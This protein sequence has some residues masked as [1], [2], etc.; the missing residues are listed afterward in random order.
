MKLFW[1]VEKVI[2]V[3][4][5]SSD[6][7]VLEW[8]GMSVQY[9]YLKMMDYQSRE[10][11]WAWKLKHD[12]LKWMCVSN[13]ESVMAVPLTYVSLSESSFYKLW[14]LLSHDHMRNL[15]QAKTS[16]QTLKWLWFLGQWK[17]ASLSESLIHL[18]YIPIPARFVVNSSRLC[19]IRMM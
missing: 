4:I 18:N 19:L 17:I 12:Q 3:R 7:N 15:S 11:N 2:E 9:V 1:Q 8:I 16:L 5:S 13:G 6:P 10:L 14:P